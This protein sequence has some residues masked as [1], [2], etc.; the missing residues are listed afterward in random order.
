MAGELEFELEPDPGWFAVPED[1]ESL[2]DWSIALVRELAGAD[3][4]EDEVRASAESV[5]AHAREMVE[6]LVELPWVFLPDPL[7][8]VLAICSIELVFGEAGDLPGADEL[9]AAFGEQRPEHLDAPQV[10]RVL[11][12]AGPAVRQQVLR[13]DGDT[14]AVSETVS[15][16][17]AVDGMDDAL[18]RITTEW[19]ALALGD[20]LTEQADRMAAGL[21]VRIG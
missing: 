10:S 9:A 5:Y 17:V 12:T 8:G 7:A 14:G 19:Q 4:P 6:D 11:L 20:E 16:V 18:L 3:A 2:H 1:L 15:H 21:V 13:Q